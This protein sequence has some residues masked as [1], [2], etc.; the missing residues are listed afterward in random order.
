[1][2]DI[3][4]TWLGTYWQKEKPTRFEVT[5]VQS[6]NGISGNMLDDGYLGEAM[7]KG[8]V[9][10]H[11]ISFVK[12]YISPKK[13]A[14]VNYN[15]TISEDGDFM[16]GKWDFFGRLGFANW[17]AHRSGENLEAEFNNYLRQQVPVAA[18]D[19]SLTPLRLAAPQRLLLSSQ[20]SECL[21]QLP[22]SLYLT[23]L[24][25]QIPYPPSLE[26]QLH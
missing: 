9:I 20:I 6:G 3:S 4:G 12:S 16:S 11:N 5:F 1:M 7:L 22:Q 15:G 10:G 21:P 19:K 18:N 13:R 25:F 23:C 17:E 2:I 24:A 26:T 14:P 8:E